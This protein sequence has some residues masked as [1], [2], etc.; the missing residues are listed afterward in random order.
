MKN[1]CTCSQYMFQVKNAQM[2]SCLYCVQH[3][4]CLQK[5]VLDSLNYLPLSLL[6]MKSTNRSSVTSMGKIY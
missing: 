6:D 1:H 3:P 5:E 4:V 2:A